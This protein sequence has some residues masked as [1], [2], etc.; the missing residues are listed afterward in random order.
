MASPIWPE[1][2]SYEED[3]SRIPPGTFSRLSRFARDSALTPA[4][5]L[6]SQL[7]SSTASQEPASGAKEDVEVS[8]SLD[9]LSDDSPTMEDW[10]VVRVASPTERLSDNDV[11]VQE[12]K[13]ARDYEQGDDLNDTTETEDDD[14]SGAQLHEIQFMRRDIIIAVMG[15]TGAGKS[16][17]ISLLCEQDIEIGHGQK[18]CTTN[19]GVYHFNLGGVRI[20]LID[21]PGFDDTNRSDTEVLGDIAYWLARAYTQHM[22]LAGIIYLHRITDVR[23]QGSAL[24]NL[25]LFKELCGQDE[26]RS[27]ILATTHWTHGEGNSVS[28]EV[29]RGRV[30]ELETTKEFWGGMIERGSRVEKHDGSE[31]SA[32]RIVSNLV[33]RHDSVT[34]KIQRQMV[35]EKRSLFET[36]AGQE[37]QREIIEERRK[38][39]ETLKKLKLDMEYALNEKDKE[40]QETIKQDRAA[41]EARI[42]QRTKEM[43]ALKINLAKLAAEKDEQFR[44]ME[45]KWNREKADLESRLHQVV[46]RNRNSGDAHAGSATPTAS[47]RPNRDIPMRYAWEN[48]IGHVNETPGRAERTTLTTRLETPSRR[49]SRNQAPSGRGALSRLGE[50]RETTVARLDTRIKQEDERILRTPRELARIETGRQEHE[51]KLRE[52]QEILA[53]LETRTRQREDEWRIALEEA[54]EAEKR[55]IRQ[56]EDEWR[57]ALEEGRRPRNGEYGRGR[58]NGDVENDRR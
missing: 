54:E 33:S 2:S 3:T 30:K 25:R 7:R 11:D 15:V 19:V 49:P 51:R 8:R 1:R 22:Q 52:H 32:L 21:T 57:I 23:M 55:R 37:L 28:E 45:R 4:G 6:L 20:W 56:R 24:R 29:G 27:V 14:S 10:D 46:V 48:G 44:K 17:F 16:T 41:L 26:L 18:S 12:V 53:R 39:E 31:A 47:D 9:E 43:E 13:V 50:E 38:A 5:W 34:L 40:W 42:D 35:D 58:R 36:A